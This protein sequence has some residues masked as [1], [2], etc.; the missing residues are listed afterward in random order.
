MTDVVCL[1]SLLSLLC[2]ERRE[3]DV[4]GLNDVAML[5]LS[6][7]QERDIDVAVRCLKGQNDDRNDVAD[8]RNV[9]SMT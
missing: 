1:F 2:R 3:M 6:P 4:I 5:C 8:E 7:S 9:R